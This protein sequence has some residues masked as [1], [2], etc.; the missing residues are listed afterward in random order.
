MYFEKKAKERMTE[1][2]YSQAFGFDIV[3]SFLRLCLQPSI[4]ANLLLLPIGALARFCLPCSLSRLSRFHSRSL[5]STPSAFRALV[6]TP[7]RAY[8]R[9]C[10]IQRYVDAV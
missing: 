3:A 10:I 6:Y 8:S 2:R 7:A 1:R 5:P 9:R 4:K